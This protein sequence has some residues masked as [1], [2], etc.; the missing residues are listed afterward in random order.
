MLVLTKSSAENCLAHACFKG[1]ISNA[2]AAFQSHP[3]YHNME[4]RYNVV[5]SEAGSREVFADFF[6]QTYLMHHKT[7][8]LSF[9]FISR[10]AAFLNIKESE[11]VPHG[12][13][14][15]PNLCVMFLA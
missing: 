8:H 13:I 1:I 10:S 11:E 7:F 6:F 3:V 12:A 14:T 5:I 9:L 15:S 2:M 4:N